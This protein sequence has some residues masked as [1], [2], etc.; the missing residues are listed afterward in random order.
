MPTFLQAW[1]NRMPSF[2]FLELILLSS[3]KRAFCLSFCRCL[4]L[5]FLLFFFSFSFFLLQ[6]FA[7][8]NGRGLLWIRCI[9]IST[10][11]GRSCSFHRCAKLQNDFLDVNNENIAPTCMYNNDIHFNYNFFVFEWSKW[12]NA[13]QESVHGALSWSVC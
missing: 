1:F 9:K 4:S 3:Q 10:L 6:Y 8:K 2:T 12:Q 11:F 7:V 5:S 13:L